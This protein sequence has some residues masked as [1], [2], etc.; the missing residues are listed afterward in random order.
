M[1]AFCY[2]KLPHVNTLPS[3]KYITPQ[4]DKRGLI[5]MCYNRSIT[6]QVLCETSIIVSLNVTKQNKKLIPVSVLD[7]GLNLVYS[8][9]G[10]DA[11]KSE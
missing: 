7:A 5:I 6:L 9:F 8:V 11:Q 1:A 10:R 2:L 4:T 3:S